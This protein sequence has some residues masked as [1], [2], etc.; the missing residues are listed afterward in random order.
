MA[1]K[2][3]MG[4]RPADR[5]RSPRQVSDAAQQ[6]VL[7]RSVAN[8]KPH[9]DLRD[10]QISHHA[11]PVRVQQR[12]V[13]I[14]LRRLSAGKGIV[15]VPRQAIIVRLRRRPLCGPIRG[16]QRRHRLTVGG[17]LCVLPPLVPKAA[18]W[19]IQQNG[20]PKEKKQ[21]GQQIPDLTLHLVAIP[22]RVSV[23]ADSDGFW[24][25]CPSSAVS[26]RGACGG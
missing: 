16:I 13:R 14:V 19:R 20:S 25:A 11:G 4:P 22:F 2:Y 15:K 5:K 3:A 8:G 9:T 23:G 17:D 12:P 18:Q 1:G 21:R 6:G 26:L 10:L 24:Q 7:V